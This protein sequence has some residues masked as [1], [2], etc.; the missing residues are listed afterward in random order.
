MQTVKMLFLATI[1]FFFFFS[2]SYG[3]DVAKI[4]VVDFQK[5]LENSS[6][7]KEARAELIEN[8]KMM[9]TDLMKIQGELEEMKNRLE[10]ERLVMSKEMRGE[11]EREYRIKLND[12]RS[13]DKK[14]KDEMRML[15]LQLMDRLQNRTIAIAREIG[16]REGYLLIIERTVVLYAPNTIDITDR[17]IEKYN[18]QYT[19][20]DAGAEGKAKTKKD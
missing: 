15:N 19:G 9:E 4:G 17:I 1:F 6:A 13:L 10:R 2:A 7:G 14:F 11:R 18:T 20:K 16:K 5:I 12:F 8:G 3:A